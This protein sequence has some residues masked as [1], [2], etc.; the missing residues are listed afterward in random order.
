[1]GA[2]PFFLISGPVI[3][4]K[5]QSFYGSKFRKSRKKRSPEVDLVVGWF[6]ATNLEQRLGRW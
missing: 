5:R 2:F 4:Q 6:G 3:G 1:M